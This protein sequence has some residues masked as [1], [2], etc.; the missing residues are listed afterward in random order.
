MKVALTEVNLISNEVQLV[1]K[2]FWPNKIFVCS[3]ETWKG[4]WMNNLKRLNNLWLLR[5]DVI[6]IIGTL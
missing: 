1:K 4:P 2:Y 5:S 3:N 6:R